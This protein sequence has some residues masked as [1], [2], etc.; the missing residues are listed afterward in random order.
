MAVGSVEGFHLKLAI[1]TVV[2]AAEFFLD[3]RWDLCVTG[4]LGAFRFVERGDAECWHWIVVS[5]SEP[6]EERDGGARKNRFGLEGIMRVKR[7][8][9]CRC[10]CFES[11]VSVSA[12]Y[13]TMFSTVDLV[14]FN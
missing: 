11:Q 13:Y 2:V 4:R 9:S 3:M 6:K 1:V 12:L 5:S 14:L 10:Y 7:C 8:F